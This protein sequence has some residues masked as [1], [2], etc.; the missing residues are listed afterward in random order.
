M[1]VKGCSLSLQRLVLQL[2]P[3]IGEGIALTACH[4]A[5]RKVHTRVAAWRSY[6]RANTSSAEEEALLAAKTVGR[7]PSGASSPT[8]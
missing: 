8:S 6:L 7:W 3:A 5:V 4:V 1:Q 2:V